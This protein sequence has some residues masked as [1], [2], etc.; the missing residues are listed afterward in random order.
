MKHVGHGIY[1]V[2]A[3]EVLVVEHILGET[4]QRL[5]TRV[6]DRHVRFNYPAYA[7]GETTRG[8]FYHLRQARRIKPGVRL[9]T[10]HDT[11]SWPK[12]RRALQI[13]N[14]PVTRVPGGASPIVYEGEVAVRNFT[15]SGSTFF[16]LEED[17]VGDYLSLLPPLP[18]VAAVPCSVS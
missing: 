15:H 6:D 4:A 1:Q 12:L 11:V 9:N 5:T 14:M 3:G 10:N 13:A 7:K 17:A 18:L 8:G 2:D 16:V